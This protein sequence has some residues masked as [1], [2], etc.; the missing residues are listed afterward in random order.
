MCFIYADMFSG[1][2]ILGDGSIALV[3]DINHLITNVRADENF[4]NK[5]NT[6]DKETKK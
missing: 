4:C 3:L 5:I 1:A 6:K 2:S